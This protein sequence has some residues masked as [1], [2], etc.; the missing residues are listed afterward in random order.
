MLSLHSVFR[1]LAM[2]MALVFALATVP[3]APARAG[4]VPT[5]EA[6][7]AMGA[8]AERAKVAEFLGREAVRAELGA[9]G[10]DPAEAQARV[11]GLSDDEVRTIAGRIDELPAGQSALGV[12]IGAAVLIF[13]VLLITDILGFTKVFNFTRSVR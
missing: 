8:A 10:V 11:A 9:L 3:L 7:A 2:P 6:V 5:E 12:I 13:I 1:A 4:L